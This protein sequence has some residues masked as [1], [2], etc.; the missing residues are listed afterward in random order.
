MSLAED[1]A[2]HLAQHLVSLRLVA[3]SEAGGCYATAADSGRR[4]CDA[5]TAREVLL[6]AQQGESSPS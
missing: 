2:Q 5:T 3:D 4:G 1:L 6:R